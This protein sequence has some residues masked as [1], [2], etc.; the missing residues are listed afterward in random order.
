[1]SQ[2]AGFAFNRLDISDFPTRHNYGL[3]LWQK[4]I[5]RILAGWVDELAVT[6]YRER[7]VT[8]FAQDDN[9]VDVHLSDDESMRG[10][11]C[12]ELEGVHDG[13]CGLQHELET[14]PRWCFAPAYG[15][16][17]GFNASSASSGRRSTVS[18][19]ASNQSPLTSLES[20][21]MVALGIRPSPTWR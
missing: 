17:E 7:E 20:S 4:H 1:V 5:E 19:A 14:R 16:S 21:S 11:Y 18:S 12:V 10:A 6:I 2:V 9:G 15:D 13:Y 3:G 8:G